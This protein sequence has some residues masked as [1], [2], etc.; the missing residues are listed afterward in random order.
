MNSIQKSCSFSE[1]K[2]PSFSYGKSWYDSA[3][4]KLSLFLKEKQKSYSFS[5]PRIHNFLDFWCKV[6]RGTRESSETG[7]ADVIPGKAD[8]IPPRKAGSFSWWK[9]GRKSW[10]KSWGENQLLI[11]IFWS[12]FHPSFSYQL[13]TKMMKSWPKKLTWKAD[14]K[15]NIVSF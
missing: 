5:L 14:L 9:A 4:K 3:K 10:G 13:F 7:K 2:Y 6:E 11:S 12:A 8:V 15:T 1:N